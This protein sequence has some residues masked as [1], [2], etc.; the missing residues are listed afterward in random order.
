MITQWRERLMVS[1]L[2]LRSRKYDSGKL[3][4]LG[5]LLGFLTLLG[6]FY[7]MP[8]VYALSTSLKAN[9]QLS[10]RDGVVFPKTQATFNYHDQELKLYYVTVNGVKRQLAVLNPLRNHVMLID[11]SNPEAAPIILPVNIVTLER[12]MSVDL[13]P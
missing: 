12:V 9:Y 7:T 8:F 10:D 2:T 13:H 4:W 3:I 1:S 6:I 11:P 5:V